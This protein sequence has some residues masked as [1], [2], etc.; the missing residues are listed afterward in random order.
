MYTHSPGHLTTE[1]WTEVELA[2]SSVKAVTIFKHQSFI[3][4]VVRSSILSELQFLIDDFDTCKTSLPITLPPKKGD[5]A[6]DP[7]DRN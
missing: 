2:V 4:F 5:I 3:K 7:R 6:R 1:H